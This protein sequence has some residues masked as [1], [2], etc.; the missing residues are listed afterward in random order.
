MDAE[1]LAI[2]DEITSGQTLDTNSQ[3]LTQRLEELGVRVLFHSTVG[4]EL[5]PSAEVFRRAIERADVVVATGGLGPTADDLTR[6]ALAARDRSPVA[7]RCGGLGVYSGD[8]RPAAAAH[9]AAERASGDVS[10]RQPRGAQSARHGAGHRAGSTPARA[11]ALP[12]DLSAWRARRNDRNVARLAWPRPSAALAA[13][14]GGSIR[15]R[16]INCFG[17]GESQIES[18]LP[19]LIRRGRRPTVGITASKATISLRIAADGATEE[20][21]YAAMS[22]PWTRSAS[23][24]ARS[25]SAKRTTS[26]RMRLSGCSAS[27]ARHWPRP[28]AA[29]RG[30]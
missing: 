26:C 15:R 18:M 12:G 21:C 29:R 6:E 14:A 28:N 27:K 3:W 17:A 9:A 8:V 1:I 25:F 10:G 23:A 13:A 24:W 5:E 30:W 20:E 7:A 4:D 16:R 19:D 2:G 22:R 11:A